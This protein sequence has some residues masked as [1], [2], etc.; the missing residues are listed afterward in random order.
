MRE[1]VDRGFAVIH[2]KVDEHTA[3]ERQLGARIRTAP[4]TVAAV[5]QI[6]PDFGVPWWMYQEL[7]FAQACGR[8]AALLSA[9]RIADVQPDLKPFTVNGDIIEDRFWQWLDDTFPTGRA[10]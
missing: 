2:G 9:D 8:P 4:V 10:R 1:I 7:D 6:D 3:P 5:S